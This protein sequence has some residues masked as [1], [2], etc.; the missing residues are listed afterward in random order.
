MEVCQGRVTWPTAREGSAG[1]GKHEVS[2]P[3]L[4]LSLFSNCLTLPVHR[5]SAQ[6]SGSLRNTLSPDQLKFR[7]VVSP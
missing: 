5:A 1:A 4:S 6:L 7:A 2:C 3:V